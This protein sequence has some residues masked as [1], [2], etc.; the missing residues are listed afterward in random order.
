M[1]EIGEGRRG[2]PGE[3]EQVETDRREEVEVG[4]RLVKS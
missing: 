1:D 2:R 4:L 3:D